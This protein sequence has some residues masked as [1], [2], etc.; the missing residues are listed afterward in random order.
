M[1]HKSL[2]KK[3]VCVWEASRYWLGPILVK[4]WTF[5]RKTGKV[6]SVS[7]G[8]HYLWISAYYCLTMYS[9]FSRV[10]A[11][12]KSRG[13]VEWEVHVICW[14][15]TSLSITMGGTCDMLGDY[16]IEYCHPSCHYQ[17]SWSLQTEEFLPNR[18]I[19]SHY[20]EGSVP[21]TNGLEFHYDMIAY[22]CC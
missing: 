14:V 16:I 1:T 6:W 21:P 5:M 11:V 4:L 9:E 20:E 19:P 22:N 17:W 8:G 3:E 18:E 10:F 2:G 7:C 15:I 12:F 13:G